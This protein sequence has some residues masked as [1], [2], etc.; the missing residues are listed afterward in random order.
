M[1]YPEYAG[2]GY[3]DASKAAIDLIGRA[4]ITQ[5]W[6]HDLPERLIA[7]RQCM[8]TTAAGSRMQ[9][10]RRE[11]KPDDVPSLDQMV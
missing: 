1:H 8:Y 6:A 3:S 10:S 2:M 9:R 4:T 5:S 7:L 11:W